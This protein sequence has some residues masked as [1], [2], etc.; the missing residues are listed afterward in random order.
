MFIKKCIDRAL[1]SLL[2]KLFITFKVEDNS[3]V[4]S[5]SE[6]KENEVSKEVEEVETQTTN[7]I[8]GDVTDKELPSPKSTSDASL[9]SVIHH[10]HATSQQQQYNAEYTSPSSTTSSLNRGEKRFLNSRNFLFMDTNYFDL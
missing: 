10:R 6:E 1:I 3:D 7:G 5:E 8:N 2:K 9:P 4:H